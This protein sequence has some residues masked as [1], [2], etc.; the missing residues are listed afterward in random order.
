MPKAP[1]FRDSIDGS[2]YV[3]GLLRENERLRDADL[4]GPS[5]GSSVARQSSALE[6]QETVQNPLVEDRPQG[7]FFPMSS[8]DM[9]IH[10]SEAAD[11]AFATR[12]REAL[13]PHSV[14]IPRTSYVRDE[15]LMLL[16]E[17]Q[18]TW[19]TPARAR[20]L[21]KV[22]LSTV[23]QYYH[24]V[25]PS[26]IMEA[27]ERVIENVNDVDRLIKC[28]LLALFALGEVYSSRVA[29]QEATFPGLPY[30]AQAR[31]MVSIPAE[32]PTMH[33]VE[34]ALLL[35]LY[36]YNLNRRHTAYLLA[37]SAVR[38]GIVMGLNMN[39]PDGLYSNRLAREHRKR[40][41]WTAYVLDRTCCS[42][43]GHPASIADEDIMVDL[44]SNDDLRDS[45]DFEDVDYTLRSIELAGL[46][47]QTRQQ[48]YSRRKHHVS[49]SQR[50][51]TTLKNITKWMETLPPHLQLDNG[52]RSTQPNSIVYLHLRFNQYLFS[53]STNLALSSLLGSAQ[54][55]SDRDNF[56]TAAD[57]IRQLNQ[58]GNFAAQEFCAHLDAMEES[59]EKACSTSSMQ[60]LAPR[61]PI[62]G[63]ENI[64]PLATHMMTAGM[65]LAE[66]SLQ[67]FLAETDLAIS[68]I[69]NPSFDPLQTPYW[70]GIWGGDEWVN[71]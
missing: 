11:A 3:D 63:N 68:G 1:L 26:S 67:E 27:L 59:M 62:A 24:I 57:I 40:L 48:L 37:S 54:S 4:A 64:V 29:A 66:P 17:S 32:R 19:P 18:F 20:F 33:T 69:D 56:N 71:G 35:V 31:R 70:P 34:I 13:T 44:P 52:K 2:R 42:K 41:W 14:H 12:F 23:C 45:T 36:S 55:Q 8:L 16:S 61:V 7:W 30:F 47:Q 6:H 51:Q 50:V 5:S 9:P 46:S 39:V 49:F 28:K 65:A 60:S 10:I 21:V 58:S 38:L 15:A 43:L 53:A 25:L 22:A